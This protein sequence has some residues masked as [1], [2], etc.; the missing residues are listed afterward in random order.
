MMTIN[1]DVVLM[2]EKI[3]TINQEE[4]EISNLDVVLMIKKMETSS[5]DVASMMISQEDVLMIEKTV[6]ISQDADSMMINQDVV[7]MMISQEEM[8]TI[9]QDVDLMMIVDQNVLQMTNQ[10]VDMVNKTCKDFR[11][12]K[13]KSFS[14]LLEIYFRESWHFNDESF[15]YGWQ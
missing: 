9:S 4:M 14:Y 7:L 6:T 1:L 12:I 5:Q 15:K 10:I 2:I 13:L 8:V 3:V 11:Q